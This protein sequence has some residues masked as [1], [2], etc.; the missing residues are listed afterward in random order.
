MA[1]AIAAMHAFPQP[2]NI[3]QNQPGL[4]HILHGPSKEYTK[5]YQHKTLHLAVSRNW[6]LLSVG[7]LV[8]RAHHLG[9]ILGHPEFQNSQVEPLWRRDLAPEDHDGHGR[10]AGRKHRHLPRQASA[11]TTWA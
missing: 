3:S 9:S 5:T 6:G 10:Q 7:V 11:N 4:L 2:P 1:S 8:S